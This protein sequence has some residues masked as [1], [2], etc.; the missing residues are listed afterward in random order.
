M[1][2]TSPDTTPEA[3]REIVR[4]L[5][6]RSTGEKLRIVGQLHRTARTLAETGVRRRRPGLS[7]EAVRR[8]VARKMLGAATFRTYAAAVGW[9]DFGEK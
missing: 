4:G 3:A 9:D 5:R 8:E 7:A 2:L 6:R 1:S